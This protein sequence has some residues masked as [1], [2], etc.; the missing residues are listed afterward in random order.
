M[1]CIYI[2][3]DYS[4]CINLGG[5]WLPYKPYRVLCRWFSGIQGDHNF[6]LQSRCEARYLHYL[7]N[8]L[9]RSHCII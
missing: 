4:L 1:I 8:A 2:Y 6:I 3:V 9:S 5:G 7:C